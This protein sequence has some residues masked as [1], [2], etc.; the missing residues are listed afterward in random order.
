MERDPRCL[1]QTGGF[2]L[3]FCEERGRRR[4]EEKNSH[5]YNKL[6]FRNMNTRNK[7]KQNK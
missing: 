7:T 6:N 5:K 1:E 3:L 2:E 4:Y